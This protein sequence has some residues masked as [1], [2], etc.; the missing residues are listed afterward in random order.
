VIISLFL[1]CFR[2]YPDYY[3]PLA[4]DF[5]SLKAVPLNFD[6]NTKPLHP[7]EQMMATFSPQSAQYLPSEWQSLMLDKKSPIIEFYP[8]HF[9]I[10]PND[11]KKSSQYVTL[12]PFIDE[13]RL[14]Q[15]LVPVY[16]TLTQEEEKRN[17]LGDNRLFIHLQNPAY[18]KF[19]EL[20]D[21]AEKQRTENNPIPL[22]KI[23]T[24]RLLGYVWHYDKEA[25]PSAYKNDQ[26]ICLKNCDSSF[27]NESV[28][29]DMHNSVHQQTISNQSNP[30]STVQSQRQQAL[31]STQ[32]SSPA[33]WSK[34]S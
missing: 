11:K 7:L 4:Y 15:A 23:L 1:S 31:S 30:G 24:G 26:V 25:L 20:S 34:S 18:P 10:D 14:L 8:Q 17:T 5:S 12:I 22:Q 27:R 6:Q 21:V 13:N 33:P 19:K 3:A 2:Y 29:K 16:S 32:V 9:W 28:E